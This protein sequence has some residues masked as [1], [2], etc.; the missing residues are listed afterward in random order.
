[1]IKLLIFYSIFKLKTV[2]QNGDFCFG[3]ISD[4]RFFS[5]FYHVYSLID[6]DSAAIWG[7][8]TSSMQKHWTCPRCKASLIVTVLERLR[9]ESECQSANINGMNKSLDYNIVL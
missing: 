4:I 3:D 8:Y 7:E 6:E 5:F 2:I 1:M 9:H